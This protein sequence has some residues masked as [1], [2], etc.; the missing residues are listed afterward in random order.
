MQTLSTKPSP[1]QAR[2]AAQLATGLDRKVAAPPRGNGK[3]AAH[4]SG[5]AEAEGALP[6]DVPDLGDAPPQQGRGIGIQPGQWR[7][8]PVARRAQ[9]ARPAVR[10][11]TRA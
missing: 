9:R 1:K 2:A 10:A 5:P 4:R 3:N 7:R 11:C 8:P 6:A